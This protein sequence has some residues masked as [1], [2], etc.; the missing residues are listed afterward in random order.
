MPTPIRHKP[1]RW[2]SED[3]DAWLDDAPARERLLNVL[4]RTETGPSLIGASAQLMA[5]AR[6]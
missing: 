1:I 2:T 4:S 6:K 5:V 3:I